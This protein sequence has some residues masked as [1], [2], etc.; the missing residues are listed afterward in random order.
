MTIW[1]VKET[2]HKRMRLGADPLRSRCSGHSKC[3]WTLL[4][5]MT[6]TEIGREAGW[7]GWEIYQWAVMLVWPA[8]IWEGREV[9]ESILDCH[10]GSGRFS[11]SLAT[12]VGLDGLYPTRL[13]W[14]W[15]FPGKN[16]GVGCHFLLQRIFPTQG[17]NP[18]LLCL[19]HWQVDSLP[20][21]H[22]GS[23]NEIDK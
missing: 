23:P 2:R 11:Q 1:W 13:L 22:L 17:L 10:A 7:Q 20:L 14:P 5:E 19:L 21:S 16:T 4:G 15:D 3:W 18:H 8:G 6:M 12:P 9:E